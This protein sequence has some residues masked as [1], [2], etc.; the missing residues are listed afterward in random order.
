[1]ETATP[2]LTFE[3]MHEWMYQDREFT[4]I[5]IGHLESELN[6]L[7]RKFGHLPA[8]ALGQ[9]IFLR[10]KYWDF[11]CDMAEAVAYVEHRCF[12]LSSD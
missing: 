1:M 4:E 10:A 8:E 7:F 9:G 11:R 5:L 3:P 12:V 6:E 2:C